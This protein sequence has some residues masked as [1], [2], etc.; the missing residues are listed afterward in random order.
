MFKSL[1]ARFILIAVLLAGSIY[2]LVDRGITLGLDLQGGTHL[3]LEV[4]DPAGALSA[5]QRTDAVDRALQIIR[6]RVDELGVAEPSI[7]K[8][9]DER[10]IVQLPGATQEEQQRAKDVIQQAAFLQ[11]QIVRPAEELQAVL[12][13][14]DRAVA[15]S[16]GT[17]GAAGAAQQPGGA[18]TGIGGLFEEAGD[19]AG[20]GA[21]DTAAANR[22]LSSKLIPAGSGGEGLFVVAEEDVP[23]VRRALE[24][25][26]VQQ[27][28]PRGTEFRW[29]IETPAA[30]AQQQ[31]QTLYLLES[32]PL[33]TGEYLEDAQAQRDP[34]FGQPLVAFQLN[35][36]GGRIFERAT[37]EHIGDFMAIVLDDRVYSAPVIRGQIADRG[38]IELGGGSIEEA[39]DLALV[40]R[41]GALPAPM[42]IV[43]ERSVGPSLGADSVEKGELAGIIALAA[44]VL[45]LIAYYR[46][47][48]VLAVVALTL[49]VVLIL[50]ALAGLDATLTLPGIAGIVLSI[51]MSVDANVL[52]FERIREELDIGRTPRLAV[53][54][55]FSNALSAIVDGQLTTLLTAFVLFQFGTGPVRGFAVTLAI[56][57]V[58]SLFSAI[59]VTRTLFMLYLD[60]RTATQGLSI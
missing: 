3:V 43:E 1:K 41:A 53:S 32:R 28:L 22:P 44:V 10:I 29:G 35:R 18:Q 30:G 48:G 36:R 27:I 19:T 52:I 4:M 45:I 8:V 7:Q 57:I 59:F 17:A 37:G 34:Q 46:F 5:A 38:Q 24:L 16:L 14:I 58:A 23:F 2:T 6:T 56:G 40:L 12:P 11:F 55:G 31:A 20:A 25:P 33:M 42:G 21:Q 49:Y 15:S 39:R 13:R 26:A 47:A 54:E 9:G 51:G 60:R 50:G